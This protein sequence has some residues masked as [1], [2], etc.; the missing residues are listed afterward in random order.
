LNLT[1]IDIEDLDRRID[2]A[3]P[4]QPLLSR[5]RD[6]ALIHLLRTHEAY[7]VGKVTNPN[8]GE[9]DNAAAYGMDGMNHAVQ[10]ISRFCPTSGSD[11]PLTFN[12]SAYLEAVELHSIAREYAKVW[13]LMSM[14]HRGLIVGSKEDDNTIGVKFAS[15]MDMELNMAPSFIAAPYGPELGEPLITPDV[16][17]DIRNSVLV[18]STKPQ[19]ALQMSGGLFERLQERVSR[20]TSE[21]WEMDPTWDLGGY[22]IAEL[23]KFRVTLDTLCVIHGV[24]SRQ[25]GAPQKILSSII[26]FHPR[27]IWERILLKRSR[28]PQNV[29]A[30]ILTDLI[31]DPDLYKSGKKQAH[32]TYHPIFSFGSNILGVSNWLLHVSNLERNV[33]DLV[34]IK[35][36][37]LHST[38]RNLKEAS[39][40]NDLQQKMRRYGL[41]LYPTIKFEFEGQKSDLDALIIDSESRFALVCQLKWLIQPG[42]IS[43]VVYNDNEIRKGIKQAQLAFNWVRSIPS[44]LVQRTGFTREEFGQLEL[45]PLVLCK[46]TLAS[47]FLRQPGVPVINERLFDWILGDPHRRDLRTL[48]RVGEELSYLPKEGKHFDTIDASATFGGIKFNLH[49]LAWAPKNPWIPSEDIR[50]PE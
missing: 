45:R 23:H 46:N 22:T 48:W 35:R 11:I 26:K 27:N 1:A 2:A 5:S 18:Q 42:R 30:A 4:S 29:V 50:I 28:L 3:V 41:Q 33:W 43:G 12:E 9:R 15:D 25:L 37:K 32:I 19:L 10:W 21:P 20:M 16:A 17:K 6:I 36:P 7:M 8:R 24:V 40:L 14:L 47:G 39:W 44:Q 38:L 49:A 34:A 31:Y 13:D